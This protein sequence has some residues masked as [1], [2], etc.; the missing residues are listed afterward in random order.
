MNNNYCVYKHTCNLNGK[1]YIGI[2][3]N[4]ERRWRCNGIEYKPH[5]GKEHFCRFWNAIQKHGWDSF[6]HE[7]L[8]DGLSFE[9]AC[10]RE[11]YYI[12]YFD[13]RNR[14]KGYNIAEG[15]NGGR[16]WIEHPRGMKGKH[17][18]NKKKEQQR[19]LMLKL[20]ADGKTGPDHWKHGHPRGMLGKHHSEEF[21]ER[22]RNIPS[23]EHPSAK[24]IAI[25]YPNGHVKEYDCRKYLLEDLG[26]SQTVVIKMLKSHEPYKLSPNCRTNRENLK[27]LEGSL[28]YY[29]DNTETTH[30]TKASCAS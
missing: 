19:E 8:E 20:N 18:S 24:R 6:T 26:V 25:Q 17:H 21:K 16:I 13:S 9:D 3:N 11:K 10:E 30:E 29:I 15:G 5:E 1:F 28:I 14:D 2:T 4:I 27:K 22:L 23:G 7:I 12:S